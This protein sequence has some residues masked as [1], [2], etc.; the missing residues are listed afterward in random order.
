MVRSRVAH[1]HPDDGFTL[2]ELAIVIAIIAVVTIVSALGLLQRK[3]DANEAT[4]IASMHAIHSA[5]KAYSAACGHGAFASSLEV[6]GIPMVPGEPGFIPPNLASAVHPHTGG[7]RFGIAAGAGSSA[8]PLDCHNGRTFTAYYA[9]G[10]PL[11]L[12]SGS[13]S[14]A[15]TADGIVWQ[16]A[17]G[18]APAEPFG[19][20]AVPVQ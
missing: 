5:Q 14:F 11:S 6:L 15:V 18:K 1:P 13:Q 8:G 17:G 2:T 9:W 12:V 4:A 7:F 10:T 19:V 16:L 20:P 3:A